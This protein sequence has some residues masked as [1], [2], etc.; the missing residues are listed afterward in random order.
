MGVTIILIIH[1]V[2]FLFF[3]GAF[4]YTRV[5]KKEPIYYLEIREFFSPEKI[6]SVLWDLDD[7][8]GQENYKVIYGDK[9]HILSKIPIKLPGLDVGEILEKTEVIIE[10]KNS[11]G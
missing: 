6:Q 1:L 8:I 2:V 7:L 11:H 4:I 5:N 10:D 3:V 9:V